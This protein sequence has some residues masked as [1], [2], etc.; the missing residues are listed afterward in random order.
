MSWGAFWH[1]Y[2]RSVLTLWD[3]SGQYGLGVLRIESRWGEIFCIRPD[4]LWGPP[5]LLYRKYSVSNAEVKRAELYLY[6]SPGL[7]GLFEGELYFY[8]YLTNRHTLSRF[9]VVHFQSY[10]ISKRIKKLCFLNARRSFPCGNESARIFGECVTSVTWI[11]VFVTRYGVLVGGWRCWLEDGDVPSS[12]ERHLVPVLAVLG[13]CTLP[14]DM[15]L[16]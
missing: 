2:M 15:I 14:L 6:S 10:G 4:R 3:S 13:H 12:L 7:H 11:R 16:S 1:G 8:I 9:Q 5:R